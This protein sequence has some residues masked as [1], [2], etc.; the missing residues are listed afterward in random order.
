ME[1]FQHRI[2]YK[3]ENKTEIIVEF[4]ASG[5]VYKDNI[6][7]RYYPDEHNFMINGTISSWF[8]KRIL[9]I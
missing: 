1:D 6:K 9:N 8:I 4:P 5:K 2:N 7:N 3:P